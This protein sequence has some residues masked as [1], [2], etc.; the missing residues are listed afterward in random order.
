MPEYRVWFPGSS[1]AIVTAQNENIARAMVER[2]DSRRVLHVEPVLPE[3]VMPPR[4]DFDKQYTAFMD[5]I[6]EQARYL[7][8][9]K[10][11]TVTRAIFMAWHDA[12]VVFDTRGDGA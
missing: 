8:K 10:G 3:P 4:D 7:Y 11:H 12:C 1:Y 2:V 9:H 5:Y 6:K